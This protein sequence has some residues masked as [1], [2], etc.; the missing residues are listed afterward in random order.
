MNMREL[1][2]IVS[3]ITGTDENAAKA[4]IDVALSQIAA[5]VAKGDEVTL[6]GFGRFA[7]RDAAA[8]AGRN[9]RTGQLMT[10]AAS[11]KVTFSAGKKFKDLVE[12]GRGEPVPKQ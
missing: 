6:K 3:D 1:A 9:P 12:F 8:R 5:S 11:R 7:A 4:V 2:R 10:I